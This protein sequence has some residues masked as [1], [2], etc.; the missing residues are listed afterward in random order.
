MF[1]NEKLRKLLNEI[2]SETKTINKCLISRLD[3]NNKNGITLAC[4]H[5]YRVNYLKKNRTNE[6]PYCG[7]SYHLELYEKKCKLCDKLTL[8]DNELCT[9]HSKEKCTFIRTNKKQCGN[10]AKNNGVFCHLHK[11]SSINNLIE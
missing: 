8:T 1:S 2:E 7:K 10:S 11:T 6:C 4:G 3:V 5:Q 9:K